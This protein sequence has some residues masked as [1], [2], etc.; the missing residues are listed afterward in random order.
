MAEF[1]VTIKTLSPIHPGSGGAD[2]NIDSDICRDAFGFPYFPAKRFKGLLYES[3]L[4]IFEMLE[5]AGFDM[6]D[7]PNL[8]K[9]FNKKYFEDSTENEIQLIFSNFYIRREKE[10]KKLCDEWKYLQATYPNIFNPFDILETFTSV[11]YQTK[12]KDGIAA[13]HSLRNLRV[14]ESGIIF[15]GTINLIG[16]NE[17]VL[18]LLALAAKNLTAAGTK[19]NRGFGKIS[20]SIKFAKGE[21]ENFYIEKWRKK[22]V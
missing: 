4:E 9:L 12:L 2:V 7:L 13:D 5:L 18:T 22:N 3:A 19:R 21:D 6:D 11:R 15:H 8:E 14:L 16:G 10:Y 20:C 1:E 17:K